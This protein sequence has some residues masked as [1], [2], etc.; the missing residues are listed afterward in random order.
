MIF[1]IYEKFNK[2]L[3]FSLLLSLL[4]LSI[5]GVHRKTRKVK[6]MKILLYFEAQKLISKSGIG[7][8]QE[9]QMEALRCEGIEYTTNSNDEFDILH[10]NTIGPKSM[11][12][13]KKCKKQNKPIVYH[14]HSTEEDFRN[15]FIFS[16]QLSV[17]FKKH[18][19][20]LYSKADAIITPTKYSKNLLENYG[21]ATPIY[22]ISNGINV[23]CYQYSEA[24]INI[25]KKTFK[26]S[27]NQK[28]VISVGLYF[29]RKGILDFI[30][31]ARKLPNITF[32][33]FGYTPL[34]SIPKNIRKII[35]NHP[36]NVIFPGYIC[37]TV[38]E[39]AYLGADAFLFPSYEETEGIVV[40]EALASNQQIVIRDIPVFEDWMENG[41]NCYKG[42]NNSEF[43]DLVQKITENKLPKLTSVMK[44]A[45]ERNLN[46][47]GK[48]LRT[49]Y[50]SI[51]I[52]KN[53][54]SCINRGKR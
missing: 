36:S 1:Q 51:Y 19:V 13:I 31:I 53:N 26:I 47:I 54:T 4:L 23:D 41:I 39:G 20:S 18:I 50:E 32:I 43:I 10:I 3:L 35:K 2:L 49:V 25:F 40:L 44:T 29:E 16:N 52:K 28:V 11:N 48:E 12:L 14:A 38:I 27:K 45:E 42:K 37:G 7:R 5:I 33:W 6:T 24:K 46:K 21:I 34:I 9:H 8:A 22:P 30:E 15:S 17:L